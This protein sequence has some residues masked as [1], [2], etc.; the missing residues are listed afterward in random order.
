M[1][2]HDDTPEDDVAIDDAHD[3][4]PEPDFDHLREEGS[5]RLWLKAILPY[6]HAMTNGKL[7]IEASHDHDDR[8]RYASWDMGI[9]ACERA[10]RIF[11]SDLPPIDYDD[12]D[13]KGG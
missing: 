7:P 6:V 1:S 5:D 3:C 4:F 8:L 10:A 13:P 2:E 9:A 11:R 12:P